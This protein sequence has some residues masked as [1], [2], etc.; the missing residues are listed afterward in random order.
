MIA[1][2]PARPARA[3]G[4]RARGRRANKRTGHLDA[5][6]ATSHVDGIV[7][8]TGLAAAR[9]SA[10]LAL[11]ELEGLARD[12]SGMQYVHVRKPAVGPSAN[13]ES[14]NVQ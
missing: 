14:E 11:L 4:K 9:V 10:T 12:V 6:G 1:H 8:E 7:R 3:T 2:A 13:P 5:G